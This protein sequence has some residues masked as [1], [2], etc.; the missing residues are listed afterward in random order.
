MTQLKRLEIE[1]FKSFSKKTTLQFNTPITGVVGPNGSGKSN[2][3][4]AFR[5]VFGEQSMKSMRSDLTSDLLFQGAGAKATSAYV[6]I[7]FDKVDIKNK[8]MLSDIIS[9]LDAPEIEIKR[10]ISTDKG[11]L[12]FINGQ[13]VR[14]KDVTALSAA[15]SLGIGSHHIINQGEADRMMSVSS[16]ERKL[17][18]EDSLGLR[19]YHIKIK[20]TQRKLDQA[21]S[22][23]KELHTKK[24][25]LTPIFNDLKKQVERIEL[26][27]KMRTDLA[28]TLAAY[29]T[30]SKHTIS[31]KMNEMN[32]QYGVIINELT[33]REQEKNNIELK[34]AAER[35]AIAMYPT[36]GNELSKEIDYVRESLRTIERDIDASSFSVEFA[37]KEIEKIQR[38]MTLKKE[39]IYQFNETEAHTLKDIFA[40]IERAQTLDEVKKLITSEQF[41][42]IQ[43]KFSQNQPENANIHKELQ[44]EIDSITET[45]NVHLAHKIEK[46]LLLH[47]KKQELQ[48]LQQKKNE[49]DNKNI[50]KYSTLHSLEVEV[51][52]LQ[53]KIFE[54]MNTKNNLEA[55]RGM[56]R[57]KIEESDIFCEHARAYIDE[58]QTIHDD[59]E[60]LT[61]DSAILKQLCERLCYKIE[62]MGGGGGGDVIDLFKE[63]EAEIAVIAHHIEDTQMSMEELNRMIKDLQSSLHDEFTEGLV[64]V[65]EMFGRNFATLFSGGTAAIVRVETDEEE[66]ISEGIEIEVTLPKKN[67]T[68]LAMLSGGERALTSIA[69][70]FALCGVTPPPFLVLDETDAALDEANSTRFS[71]MLSEVSK[72]IP[73]VVITHNRETMSQSQKL[74]GVTIPKGGS[75]VVL[76]VVLEEALAYAK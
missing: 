65:N 11:S 67:I 5:F 23:I 8:N 48:D 25:T 74:F 26:A 59:H 10:T 39:I 49:Q 21:L 58:P 16:K 31:V 60:L 53:K 9:L 18:I 64:K 43:K 57:N 72:T 37:K 4:E 14:L 71:A 47:A 70:L 68:S 56:L 3:V 73:L 6:A 29:A 17:M 63:T 33:Q 52:S 62:D 40:A 28:I 12:Y 42:M 66:G 55:L 50:E 35:A 61:K 51:S 36:Q 15:M 32:N 54:C 24:Q 1:G 69:L 30:V 38:K 7:T 20:E 44:E 45:I 75:S 46:E 27:K 34:A 2:I 41:Q 22:N 13:N 19:I 76:S